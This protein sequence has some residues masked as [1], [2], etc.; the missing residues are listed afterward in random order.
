M[1]G[2]LERDRSP[3]WPPVSNDTSEYGG[4]LAC[5]VPA[6]CGLTSVDVP[7]IVEVVALSWSRYGVEHLA[8]WANALKS[9][10]GNP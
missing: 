8:R 5:G 3:V 2:N 9:D 1:A 7:F 4:Q 10:V 6:L